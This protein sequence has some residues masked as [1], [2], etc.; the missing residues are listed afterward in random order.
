LIRASELDYGIY[1]LEILAAIEAIKFFRD[2]LHGIH[3]KLMCDKKAVSLKI[4]K[5]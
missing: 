1:Y 2:M 4:R 3:L 5:T